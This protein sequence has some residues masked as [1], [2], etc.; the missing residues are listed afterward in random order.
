MWYHLSIVH[1]ILEGK[2]L[3]RPKGE[4]IQSGKAQPNIYPDAFQTMIYKKENIQQ[5]KP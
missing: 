2:E 4:L 1:L 5:R 3:M